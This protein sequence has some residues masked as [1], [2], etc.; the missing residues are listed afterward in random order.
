M[1]LSLASVGNGSLSVGSVV[2]PKPTGLALKDLM[3]A[4]IGV[5][6]GVTPPAGWT[7]LRT[8]GN[9]KLYYKLADS[10]D[11]AATD[12]TFTGGGDIDGSILRIGGYRVSDIITASNG[13]TGTNTTQSTSGITPAANSLL[14]IFTANENGRTVS[15]QAIATS[16]PSWTEQYDRPN[17]GANT[18]A[19]SCASATR[20]ESTASGNAS[21]TFSNSVTAAS[22]QIVA[23]APAEDV[24]F[25]C[26]LYL[27]TFYLF[28]QIMVDL[29]E[30]TVSLLDRRP[31][32]FSNVSKS[33]PV[34][35]DNEPK[36]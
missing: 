18:A 27:I 2:I 14:L 28:Q 10:A 8:D 15:G 34:S 19:I 20:P 13:A 23:I 33:T 22:V 9:S 35:W 4:Q 32:R 7:S 25:P 24:S 12:F 16:N 6:S 5:L 21:A 31:S 36:S 30:A 29:F 1:A 11:V 17:A 3:I 26:P